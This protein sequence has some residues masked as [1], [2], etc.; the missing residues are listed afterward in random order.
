MCPNYS[1]NEPQGVRRVCGGVEHVKTVG[2]RI[3]T[4]RDVATGTFCLLAQRDPRGEHVQSMG[5]ARCR[6]GS[7]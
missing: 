3:P 2:C 6:R 7:E 4:S 5:H 1:R